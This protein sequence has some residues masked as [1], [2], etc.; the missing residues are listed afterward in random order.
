MFKPMFSIITC[1]YNSE[2]FIEKNLKSVTNQ[3]LQ[4][5]EHIIIDGFSQ[6]N[7]YE[8]ASKYA[9]NYN[10]ILIYQAKPKGIANAMNEGI[11]LARGEWLLFLNSDDYLNNNKVLEN[12]DNFIK[13]NR[14]NWYYGQA[15]YVGDFDRKQ[16][17]YPRRWY[18]RHFFYPL[19]FWINFIN[20]QAIFLKKD[21]FEK[22]GLYREDLVGGMDY[23]YWLRIGAKN[24]P[25]FIPFIIS[26]FRVGG[27]STDPKNKI[28]NKKETLKIRRLYTRFA[29]LTFWPMQIYQKIKK[30]K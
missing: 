29:N 9:K 23:E 28:I 1:S 16:N 2:K 6:D 14:A 11:K 13:N 30:I 22:Y 18:H 17:I 19:L 5:F 25:K 20:H 3:S 15:K 21:L 10:H 26:D 8:I 4:N 27:F 7:T 24:K 12:V